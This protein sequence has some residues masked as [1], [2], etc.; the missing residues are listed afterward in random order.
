MPQ[1]GR[2]PQALVAAGVG[3][4]VLVAIVFAL[5][6]SD[7]ERP[8]QLGVRA[9]TT[10]SSTSSTTTPVVETTTTSAATARASTV[11][12]PAATTAR[13][14]AT[15]RAPTGVTTTTAPAPSQ[16]PAATLRSADGEVQGSQGSYCWQ[17]D[18][19]GLCGDTQDVDPQQTLRVRRGSTVD[20]RWDIAQQPAEV[21]AKYT[22]GDDPNQWHD[23]GGI[24]RS[25]PSQF[26]VDF[27]P[28][29][30]RIAVFSRWSK[31]D[32]THYFK[33]EVY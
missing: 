22:P 24:P 11:P 31:G 15:T 2:R 9:G 1:W 7:P 23:F 19:R 29:V 20:L 27:E 4:L 25:N 17:N 32:V 3:A 16:P 26:T 5:A 14:P 12:R 28:G 10:S 13:G 30:H 8:T 33:V 18:D 21:Q 6:S